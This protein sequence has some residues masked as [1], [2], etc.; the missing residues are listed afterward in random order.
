MSASTASS[1][2]VNARSVLPL[3]NIASAFLAQP[4]AF[5]GPALVAEIFAVLLTPR[6][7]QPSIGTATN[8]VDKASF[9]TKLLFMVTPQKNALGST[10]L[11]PRWNSGGQLTD[12]RHRV[13]KRIERIGNQHLRR[14]VIHGTGQTQLQMTTLIEPK[15]KRCF[16]F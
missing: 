16:A 3:A 11:F 1:A 2:K 8:A 5:S 15:G 13:E 14:L 6:L 7:V 10:L 12:F 9:T 4:Y